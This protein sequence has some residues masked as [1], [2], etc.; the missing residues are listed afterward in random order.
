VDAVIGWI[1]IAGVVFLAW[2]A[3]RKWQFIAMRRQVRV[4]RDKRAGRK[5]AKPR[6]L[7]GMWVLAADGL[8]TAV[9]MQ[10]WAEGLG[11]T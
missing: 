11:T 10:R 4:L 5:V 2:R 9:K 1:V 3:V 6:G 7:D 8:S